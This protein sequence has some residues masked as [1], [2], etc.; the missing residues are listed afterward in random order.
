MVDKEGGGMGWLLSDP[1]LPSLK[2]FPERAAEQRAAR[3][4]PQFQ[5]RLLL[6]FRG[7]IPLLLHNYQG[8]LTA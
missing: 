5:M 4:S 2:F 1:L 8:P 7:T 3:A 6:G